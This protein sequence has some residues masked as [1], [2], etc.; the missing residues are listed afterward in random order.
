MALLAPPGHLGG[1]L[2]D[3]ASALEHGKR[4]MAARD[5]AADRVLQRPLTPV[6]ND[7]LARVAS[8]FSPE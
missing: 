8:Y 3:S 6:E 1:P 2:G 4:H 7:R 5:G